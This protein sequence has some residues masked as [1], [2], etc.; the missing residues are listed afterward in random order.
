MK[1]VLSIL[2]TV[3]FTLTALVG[4]SQKE[5]DVTIRIAGMKG[6]T[7]IGL[8]QI[9]ENNANKKAANDYEFSIVGAADEISPKLIKGEL[10]MAAVP[11]NLAS[12]LYN[13]TEGGMQMLAINTLG[14]LYITEKGDTVQSWSDLKEK[15]IYATGKGTTPEF[16][17]RYILTQNGIDPDKDV[18]IEWKSEATEIVAALKSADSGIAMLPQPYVV[19]ALS[20]VEGLRV[21]LDLT[22]AWD[23]LDNGSTLVTGVLV[24]RKEFAEAHPEAVKNF[25]NEY[26]VS[27]KFVNENVADAAQLVEK[28]DIFKAAIAEKAIPDCNI[29]FVS[30]ADMKPLVNGYLSVLH[31]QNPQSVGGKLPADDFYY[32]AK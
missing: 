11:A 19:S 23:A 12:V 20:N 6:P 15:T 28:F 14:V 2:F 21:A 3:L 27:T 22:E 26:E 1:K 9:M 25:L 5:D 32:E 16:S 18:T 30:G 31:E 10:D 24:V 4:C 8:I 13:K 29:T 7:S 17:L